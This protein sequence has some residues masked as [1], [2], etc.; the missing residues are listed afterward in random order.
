MSDLPLIVQVAGVV[1]ALIG[2]ILTTQWRIA[3]S[4]NIIVKKIDELKNDFDIK[5][6]RVERDLVDFKIKVSEEYLT[7]GSANNSIQS[8][9]SEM[10]V[11]RTDMTAR[12]QR[13]EDR[14]MKS[15]SARLT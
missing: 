8:I 13:I 4:E 6:D 5:I 14:M 9:A 2:L 1:I 12:L 15:D 11:T 3:A 10:R 7:Q